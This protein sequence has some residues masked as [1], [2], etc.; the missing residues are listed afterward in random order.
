MN[1]MEMMVA[2]AVIAQEMRD[3]IRGDVAMA[4]AATVLSKLFDDRGCD[5]KSKILGAM[6]DEYAQ[7]QHEKIWEALDNPQEVD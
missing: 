7:E 6:S 5:P 4:R 1:R 2:A 3:G